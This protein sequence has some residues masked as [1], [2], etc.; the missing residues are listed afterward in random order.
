MI[1]IVN[2][3]L[4]V[5]TVVGQVFFLVGLTLLVLDWRAQSNPL[6]K[7]L[8]RRGILFGFLVSLAA[9]A[10]SVYYSNIV[11]YPPCSLC[12]VQRI[13]I[14]PQVFLLGLAW[15]RQDKQIIDYALL[16]AGV[17]ALVA[18]YQNYLDYG[19]AVLFACGAGAGTVS[20]T[21][22]YVLEFGYITIP[23]MS[24]TAFLLLGWCLVAARRY[25]GYSSPRIEQQ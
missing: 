18:L 24:L 11:G 8:G 23:M 1:V 21:Q 2:Q 19:G 5:L 15:W 4:A 22:R 10:V 25:L 16:L 13:F 12:W 7:F 3:I 14:Y 20:C 6:L 17:G 9:M